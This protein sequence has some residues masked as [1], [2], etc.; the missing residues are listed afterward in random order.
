MYSFL[1]GLL[2]LL[3]LAD[4]WSGANMQVFSL[5][6]IKRW[7]TDAVKFDSFETYAI[8]CTCLVGS[9]SSGHKV[10]VT[11]PLLVF[12]PTSLKPVSGGKCQN[13]GSLLGPMHLLS[14]KCIS[15]CPR[16]FRMSQCP[17]TMRCLQGTAQGPSELELDVDKK[18]VSALW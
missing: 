16:V 1:R 4:G 14:H 7:G 18:P 9:V 10:G 5:W 17:P 2:G 8:L 3:P 12:M 15:W 13:W 6:D 11:A